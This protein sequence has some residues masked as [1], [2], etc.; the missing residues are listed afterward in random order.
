MNEIALLRLTS[1]DSTGMWYCLLL[2]SIL[3]LI[4]FSDQRLFFSITRIGHTDIP[5]TKK[6]D[7]PSENV[8]IEDVMAF[9]FRG[10][11][12]GYFTFTLLAQWELID[13]STTP[14]YMVIGVWLGYTLIKFILEMM[15][16]L[17]WRSRRLLL[18]VVV[19][20]GLLKTK[21]AFLL[22][23]FILISQYPPINNVIYWTIS[24]GIYLV[25]YIIGY[26]FFTNPYLQLIRKKI[27][28][29]ILYICTL[30]I[31]PLW[32]LFELINQ[33]NA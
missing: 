23:I 30:E 10:L 28:L 17:F 31:G 29:F 13:V 15:I 22:L 26:L 14:I 3:L 11:A 6:I 20:R 25:Y 7:A 27:V 5:S 24:G 12:F 9:V 21:A 16:G 2:L 1:D 32:V 4:K 19:R 33:T 8:K 18:E